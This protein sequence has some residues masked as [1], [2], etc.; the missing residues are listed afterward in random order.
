VQTRRSLSRT[1]QTT[2]AVNLSKPIKV[3]KKVIPTG[4]GK[5]ALE[6][7]LLPHEGEPGPSQ[8]DTRPKSDARGGTFSK[9]VVP[10]ELEILG[11]CVTLCSTNDQ[12]IVI[13]PHTQTQT[14]HMQNIKPHK[15]QA[16]ATCS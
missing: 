10:T 11:M 8:Y 5:N 4:A 7:A 1:S 16:L 3:K 9:G 12:N 13:S 2:Y 14:N 15:N 6:L